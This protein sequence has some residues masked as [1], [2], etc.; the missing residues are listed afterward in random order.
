M[1]TNKKL[2]RDTENGKI[3]G[4]CAG[5]AEYFDMDVTVVRLIWVLLFFFGGIG[6]LPYIILA[7]VIEPKHVAVQR[8]Q[9]EIHKRETIEPDDD[10]FAKYDKKQ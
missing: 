7:I 1:A 10:P 5:M 9:E 8:E 4:V 2:Y 6:I 3:F